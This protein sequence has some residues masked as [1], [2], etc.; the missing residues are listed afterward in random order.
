MMEQTVRRLYARRTDETPDE[1]LVR[2]RAIATVTAYAVAH[3]CSAWH[4]IAQV[5]QE[6]CMCT[7]CRRDR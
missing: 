2:E 3:K 1:A 5:N 4:A 6:L 7:P